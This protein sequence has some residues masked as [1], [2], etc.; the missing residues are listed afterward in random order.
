MWLNEYGLVFVYFS[1]WSKIIYYLIYWVTQIVPALAAWSSFSW[2]LC[3]VDFLPLMWA[4][5]VFFF[6]FFLLT[7][8]VWFYKLVQANCAAVLKSIISTESSDFF[9]RRSPVKMQILVV[10]ILVRGVWLPLGPLSWHSKWKCV[11]I[12]CNACIHIYKCFCIS[13]LYPYQV[14]CELKLTHPNNIVSHWSFWNKRERGRP[15]VFER[16]TQLKCTT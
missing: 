15:K 8:L 16:M 14:K 1:L 12:L 10:P 9:G 11:H 13:Y 4:C 6:S 2:V 3:P 7:S 5:F